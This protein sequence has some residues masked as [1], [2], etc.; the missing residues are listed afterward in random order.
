MYICIGY[1]YVYSD[2]VALMQLLYIFLLISFCHD[3]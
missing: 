2:H 3:S 1:V